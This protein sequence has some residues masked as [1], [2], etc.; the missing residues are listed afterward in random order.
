MVIEAFPLLPALF[1]QGNDSAVNSFELI[2]LEWEKA[3]VYQLTLCEKRFAGS[4][5][6][7]V[8]R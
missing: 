8:A 4:S 3:I 7:A 6:T 5:S 2:P 1:Y